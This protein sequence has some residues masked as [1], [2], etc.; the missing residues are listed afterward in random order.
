MLNLEIQVTC[1]PVVEE[2][3]LDIA[4]GMK[5]EIKKINILS[6]PY[7][8]SFILFSLTQTVKSRACHESDLLVI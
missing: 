7:A 5:L 6:C 1:K 3:L 2:A 8:I 4:S